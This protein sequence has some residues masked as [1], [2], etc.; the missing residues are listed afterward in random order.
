MVLLHHTMGKIVIIFTFHPQ[1]Y[2]AQG[3]LQE[4]AVQ[5]TLLTSLRVYS[6]VVH[7]LLQI[8]NI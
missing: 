4:M 6:A 7:R 2:N 1:V 5:L 3:L 8:F